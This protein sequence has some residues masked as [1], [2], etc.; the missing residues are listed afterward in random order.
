MR[1]NTIP[2]V[3]LHLVCRVRSRYWD[4][5]GVSVMEINRQ[6]IL[7]VPQTRRPDFIPQGER[8]RTSERLSES[9]EWRLKQSE[10]YINE[11][12]RIDSY[13]FI[14]DVA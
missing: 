2:I 12:H 13:T 5:R 10:Y 14:I 9:G 7:D 4:D 3:N 11:I 6:L 1:Y 8:E